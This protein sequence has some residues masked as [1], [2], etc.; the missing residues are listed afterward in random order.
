MVNVY[1]MFIV[2]MFFNHIHKKYFYL[3]FFILV[4]LYF[5]SI[6]LK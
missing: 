6:R 2:L 3:I 1:D 5:I 4:I